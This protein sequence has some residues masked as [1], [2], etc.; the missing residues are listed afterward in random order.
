VDVNVPVTTV[1]AFR[2]VLALPNPDMK[3]SAAEAET[4]FHLLA[5][6]AWWQTDDDGARAGGPVGRWRDRYLWVDNDGVVGVGC[7]DCQLES[8]TD[9]I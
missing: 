8:S 7:T 9:N 5:G 3:T 6:R 1:L 2:I 4:A